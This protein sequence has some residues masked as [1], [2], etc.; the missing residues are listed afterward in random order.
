[1]SHLLQHL[2]L[3]QAG[4]QGETPGST[5]FV[6]VCVPVKH[7]DRLHAVDYVG[8]PA[9]AQ[10]KPGVKDIEFKIKQL[11]NDFRIWNAKVRVPGQNGVHVRFFYHGF[12][13][14]KKV[15][16]QL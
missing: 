9:H 3:Y 16:R 14:G 7:P 11:F 5:F 12:Q 15:R 13:S 1:M 2:A 6:R 4:P 10:G 8:T